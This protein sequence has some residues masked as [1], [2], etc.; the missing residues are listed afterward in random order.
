MEL[1]SFFLFFQDMFQWFPIFAMGRNCCAISPLEIFFIFLLFCD[2]CRSLGVKSLMY[3]IRVKNVVGKSFDR[4]LGQFP[5]KFLSRNQVGIE[6]PLSRKIWCTYSYHI[7]FPIRP[8]FSNNLH[9][10]KFFA[11]FF[12]RKFPDFK[13]SAS[14]WY[15]NVFIFSSHFRFLVSTGRD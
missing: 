15:Y 6:L 12:K 3:E 14:S 4:Y 2:I 9:K 7:F 10:K 8:L 13:L 1:F 5:L 11:S